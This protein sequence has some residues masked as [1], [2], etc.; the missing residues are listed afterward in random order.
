MIVD[1]HC[2]L[3]LIEQKGYD[4]DEII[5]DAV[6]RDV[7]ILQTISTKISQY[8]NL[9]KY[10]DKYDNVFASIGNHPCNVKEEGVVLAQ[11]IIDICDKDLKIIGIGETGLDYFHDTSFVESQK[12]SFL[13]HIAAS[14][15]TQLPL[16][17]HSRDCDRDMIDILQREQKSKK[18][19]ALLHCFSSSKELAQRAIELGMYISFSGIITFKNAKLVQEV[20][21]EAPEGMILVETDSPYLA[22]TPYRGQ[23]NKPAYTADTLEF[24]ADLRNVDKNYLAKKTTENFFRIFNKATSSR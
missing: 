22:P 8:R 21:K 23:D 7:K 17:I 15:E 5:A 1:S 16:I 9:K 24:L 2:H 3:D 6:A 11:E 20:A 18:F 14:Q 13:N 12:Q 4:I 19:P 10:T